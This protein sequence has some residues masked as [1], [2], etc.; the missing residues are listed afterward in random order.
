MA[1][2]LTKTERTAF[3][4]DVFDAMNH[5]SNYSWSAEHEQVRRSQ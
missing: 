5:F 1:N 3:P 2:I 4:G